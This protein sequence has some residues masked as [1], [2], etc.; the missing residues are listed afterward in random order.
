VIDKKIVLGQAIQAG[1]E[2][3]SIANLST[4]WVD[5]QLRESDG[6]L[7]AVGSTATLEFA[8]YP[9]QIF[10]GRIAFLYP[11]VA[12]AT[13]TLRARIV[14]AN[15]DGK[16][17]PGMYATV[18]VITPTVSV[19]TIPRTAAVQTGTRTI[20]FVDVGGGRLVP[21]EVTL[22]EV[23]GEFAEVIAGLTAG[24]SVVTSAQFLIDSESN[25]G[26]VMRSMVGN[27]GSS[28]A[29]PAANDMSGM[30]MSND[31]GADTRGMRGATMPAAQKKP[32]GGRQ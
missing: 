3:Y 15:S 7:A 11:T 14:V 9:G 12:E 18:H 23:V 17:K 22:G 10:R 5:V 27:G 30:D 8:A 26:E 28:S 25:L 6:A 4:V 1:M 29:A 32:A 19:L 16:L 21:R 24:Q 31:K 13:R 20:V 2:V